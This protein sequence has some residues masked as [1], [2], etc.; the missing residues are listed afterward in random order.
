MIMEKKTVVQSYEN[1]R[2]VPNPS[3]INKLERALGARLPRPSK[4]KN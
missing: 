3:I 2:A 1:G 4:K